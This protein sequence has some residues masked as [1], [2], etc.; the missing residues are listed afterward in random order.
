VADPASHRVRLLRVPFPGSI[1]AITPLSRAS[2][3]WP[4]NVTLR[5]TAARDARSYDVW[6]GTAP[7]SLT[8]IGTASEPGFTISRPLNE[9]TTYY[10]RVT[11]RV[12]PFPAVASPVFSFT[13]TSVPG[14]PP[15]QPENPTPFNFSAGLPTSLQLSWTGSGASRYDVYLGEGEYVANRVGI[16]S[17][18]RFFIGDLK[19]NTLYYWRVVAINDQGESSSY[20]WQFITG[21]AAG[22]P[23]LI[24]TVAG[25]PLPNADGSVATEA[26]IQAPRSV[27]SDAAGNVFF[28]DGGRRLMRM[29]AVTGRLSMLF[30]PNTGTLRGV[31]ADTAGNVY[32]AQSD[33]VVR[34]TRSGQRTIFAGQP[35]GTEFSGISSIA[36]DRQN[37]LYIADTGHHSIRSVTSGGQVRTE[38]GDGTC[39]DICSPTEVAADASGNVYVY[40]TGRVLRIRSDGV[41]ELVTSAGGVSGLAVDAAGSLYIADSEAMMIRRVAQ[42]GTVTPWAGEPDANGSA[43][44]FFG[45]GLPAARAKFGFPDG[46]AFTNAGE[47]L[48]ADS[49]N[50]RIRK[51]DANGFVS[52]IAGM[53]TTAGTLYGPT[54]VAAAGDTVY[55]ADSLNHLI[56]RVW[57]NRV[58]ETVA[59]A[60]LMQG[61][62][63][64]PAENGSVLF[65]DDRFSWVY[66]GRAAAVRRVLLNGTQARTI[67]ARIPRIGGIARGTDGEIYVSDTAG[68]RIL[69]FSPDGIP[70][71]MAGNGA[72]GFAGD[73][74]PASVAQVNAP[75]AL[76][77]GVDGSL[78]VAELSRVRRITPDGNIVTVAYENANGL[79]LDRFGNLYL[80][81]GRSIFTVA[82]NGE[83]VRIAGN[84]RA[85]A[86]PNDGG[87]AL[88]TRLNSPRGIA[89]SQSDE[90]YFADAGDHVVR[91]LIRNVPSAITITAGNDQTVPSGGPME[92]LRVR[93]LGK[94]GQPAAGIGVQF[95]WSSPPARNITTAVTNE[96]G[97]AS[98]A[99][100]VGTRTGTHT[101]TATAAGVAPVQFTIR[102]GQ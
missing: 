78:Y 38:A 25:R 31:A 99:P 9:R 70:T 48:I 94:T 49:R 101:I 30:A 6:L 21:S 43:F 92:V 67:D 85:S 8:Q 27:A 45:D 58:L 98:V 40:G 41:V 18:T 4:R 53:D 39:G 5:W 63:V 11:S 22:L 54:D 28:I 20:R 16:T 26:P 15:P 1:S 82:A 66:P 23:W 19:P 73:G 83:L 14:Q 74:G 59:S 2:E 12:V 76:V 55:I 10:W 86:G 79:A 89:I 33:H 96:Q 37:R 90:I 46:I 50:H 24:E 17:E 34:I 93:V 32:V 75:G 13:T 84:D 71:V 97:I 64:E 7:D 102:I 57:P 100:S 81:A 47:L 68:H 69:R 36:T 35:G 65:S 72:P 42:D 87:L 61:G 56:R 52:T 51:I 62:V 29:D 80:S 44:G 88:A 60:D 3:T 91:R 77:A 95:A